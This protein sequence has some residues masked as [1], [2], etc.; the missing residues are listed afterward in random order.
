L[1]AFCGSAIDVVTRKV[2]SARGMVTVGQAIGSP[3]RETVSS[4]HVR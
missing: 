2:P 1:Y 4:S 3:L